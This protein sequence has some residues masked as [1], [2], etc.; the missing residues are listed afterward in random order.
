ADFNVKLYS[1][2][3]TLVGSG[4]VISANGSSATANGGNI[5][6]YSAGAVQILG[7]LTAR[8]GT[9]SGNGGNI[10][11]E[12]GNFLNFK[13]TIDN[14]A[15]AGSTSGTIK[16]YVGS[17]GL[18]VSNT[19]ATDLA[20]GDSLPVLTSNVSGIKAS[21]LSDLLKKND[22][23]MEGQGNL[24][25]LAGTLDWSA[26][27]APHSL[28]IN[29]SPVTLSGTITGK[30]GSVVSILTYGAQISLGGNLVIRD[31]DLKLNM[32]NL[33]PPQEGWLPDTYEGQWHYNTGSFLG[34]AHSLSTNGGAT[35]YFDAQNRDSGARGGNTGT[36]TVAAGDY[37]YE[38]EFLTGNM[39][40]DSGNYPNMTVNGLGTWGLAV[41]IDGGANLVGLDSSK[42]LHIRAVTV[43]LSQANLSGVVDVIASDWIALNNTRFSGSNLSLTAKGDLSVSGGVTLPSTGLTIGLR[44]LLLQASTVKISGGDLRL[45]FAVGGGLITGSSYTQTFQGAGKIFK[46]DYFNQLIMEG[47]L[48]VTGMAA[49]GHYGSLVISKGGFYNQVTKN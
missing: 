1:T 32:S 36:I 28:Y 16:F 31:I 33:I 21:A 11:L 42:K 20:L 14:S 46:S 10:R 15:A 47:N 39:T 45:N 6:L 48:V 3:M 26:A 7:S 5:H 27:T 30:S 29:S 4:A 12:I 13:G 17:A 25:T 40:S 37:F 43:D 44:N 41:F 34:G 9:T 24:I 35:I 23:V 19:G 22:I 49:T 38:T 2:T 18:T 8:G